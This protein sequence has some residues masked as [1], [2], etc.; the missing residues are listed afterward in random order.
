MLTLAFNLYPVSATD[1][2]FPAIYIEPAV[3]VDEELTPG[4]SQTIAADVA[5]PE[6]NM[7]KDLEGQPPLPTYPARLLCFDIA[8]DRNCE[9]EFTLDVS[10]VAPE[11]QNGM[12][13]VVKPLGRDRGAGTAQA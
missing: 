12:T 5:E 1:L 6:S 3:T 10:T 11:Q 4:K 8:P 7:P 2:E 13:V 9:A